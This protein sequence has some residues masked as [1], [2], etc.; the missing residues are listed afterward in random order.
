M[1]M[2]NALSQYR[3]LEDQLV[4][5]RWL[6]RGAESDEED[7]LLDEMEEVWWQLE[8]HERET[9]QAEAPRSLIR[10]AAMHSTRR[11]VDSDKDANPDAPPR[12]L[13]EAA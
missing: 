12:R 11:I 5:V 6:N 1:L 9:L 3:E 4:Y 2:S 7:R 10:D 8:E 13:E